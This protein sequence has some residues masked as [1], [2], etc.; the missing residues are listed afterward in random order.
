MTCFLEIFDPV[1]ADFAD[2]SQVD[3]LGLQSKSINAGADKSL[4]HQIGA[5]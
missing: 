1:P 2:Y 3:M 5:K 4:F